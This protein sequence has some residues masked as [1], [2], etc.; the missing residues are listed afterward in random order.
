MKIKIT[1]FV[2]FI[3]IV[4][5]LFAFDGSIFNPFN[6][7]RKGIIFGLGGGL[8]SISTKQDGINGS[9]IESKM[10]G[11]GI[12]SYIGYAPSNKLEIYYSSGFALA[13]EDDDSRYGV[14]SYDMIS[15]SYFLSSRLKTIEWSP[16][17]FLSGGIGSSTFA[18]DNVLLTYFSGFRTLRP[19]KGFGFFAGAGYELFKHFRINLKLLNNYGSN[20]ESG[21]KLKGSSTTLM[22]TLSVLAF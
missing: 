3:L 7:I 15:F 18:T 8:A 13:G 21:E 16:S 17:L 6:G 12:D 22:F 9:N 20:K 14:I 10:K 4:P 19:F 5:N 1:L 11:W 2:I